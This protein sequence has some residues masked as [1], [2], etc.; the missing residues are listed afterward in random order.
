MPHRAAIPAIV[1]LLPLAAP[2]GCG[3]GSPEAGPAEP[4]ATDQPL[5]DRAWSTRFGEFSLGPWST[6]QLLDDC[7]R[8]RHGPETLAWHEGLAEW[9]PLGELL[10]DATFGGSVD[11]GKRWTVIASRLDES[12]DQD[13]RTWEEYVAAMGSETPTPLVPTTVRGPRLEAW[14]AQVRSM[15]E[16]ALDLGTSFGPEDAL[17]GNGVFT[18]ATLQDVLALEAAD[19]VRR[20]DEEQ[21]LR[22]LEALATVGRQLR[23]GVFALYSAES[24]AAET[25]T[26][27]EDPYTLEDHELQHTGLAAGSIARINGIL[28]LWPDWSASPDARRRLAEALQW[29]DLDELAAAHQRAMG[30]AAGSNRPGWTDDDRNRRHREMV[31]LVEGLRD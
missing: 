20:G 30:I 7:E 12:L 21:A 28:S 8:G 31:A 1:L 10:P 3:E 9:R 17:D 23:L 2:I 19:A 25:E 22:A 29:V 27:K 18:M 16:Q 14:R 6:T 24:R 15:I 26:S 5:D 11:A 13:D 4:V